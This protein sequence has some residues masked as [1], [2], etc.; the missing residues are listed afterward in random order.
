MVNGSVALVE[1]AILIKVYYSLVQLASPDDT[2][3]TN[4]LLLAYHYGTRR[5][6]RIL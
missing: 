6:L 1:D 3:T 5:D 2:K 4:I